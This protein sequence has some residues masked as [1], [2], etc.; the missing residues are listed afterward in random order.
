MRTMLTGFTLAPVRD[1]PPRGG[2]T[3]S[4]GESPSPTGYRGG[5]MA[6]PEVPQSPEALRLGG[7]L[8]GHHP[9]SDLV[10]PS[11]MGTCDV[12]GTL[13]YSPNH[14]GLLHLPS[15]AEFLRVKKWLNDHQVGERFPHNRA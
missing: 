7:L 4:Q 6:D 10:R 3:G 9:A 13:M 8:D 5:P 14:E 2:L 11:H 1:T 12:C 15:E